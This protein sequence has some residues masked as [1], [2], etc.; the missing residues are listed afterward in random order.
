MPAR[1]SQGPWRTIRWPSPAAG[2]REHQGER[3]LGDTLTCEVGDVGDRDTALGGFVHR[4]EPSCAG[5][6]EADK[7]ELRVGAQQ[8]VGK[9][10][11]VADDVDTS[12]PAAQG[13]GWIAGP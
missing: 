5:A 13:S 8:T 7:A 11:L 9:W 6:D 3:Q 2:D 12:W 10:T 1:F 4:H